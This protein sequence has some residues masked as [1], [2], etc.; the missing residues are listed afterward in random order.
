MPLGVW[1]S[2]LVPQLEHTILY[3]WNLII[4]LSL[5]FCF[6]STALPLMHSSRLRSALLDLIKVQTPDLSPRQWCHP[7]ATSSTSPPPPVSLSVYHFPPLFFL[8]TFCLPSIHLTPGNSL[9][10]SFSHLAPPPP[11]SSTPHLSSP[12][13]LIALSIS[14]AED[15]YQHRGCF[16]SLST[17]PLFFSLSSSSSQKKCG[18]PLAP[19]AVNYLHRRVTEFPVG[20][21]F[22]SS[23]STCCFFMSWHLMLIY[24]D[25]Q[26]YDFSSSYA[27][28][29]VK[30]R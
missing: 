24:D 30:R 13:L 23:N 26:T 19:S 27:G 12:Q 8:C 2:P 28:R 10:L 21:D 16:S 11:H 4:S 1:G 3:T 17:L 25:S 7:L 14:L 5:F 29:K 18:P 6:S 9:S 20:S 22:P 15:Q